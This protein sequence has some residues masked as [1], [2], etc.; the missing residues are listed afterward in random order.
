MEK[1]IPSKSI[2]ETSWDTILISE[3]IDVKPKLIRRVENV[4]KGTTHQEDIEILN[5][6]TSNTKAPSP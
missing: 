4:I 2:Q 1:A 6:Y 3:K 5:T